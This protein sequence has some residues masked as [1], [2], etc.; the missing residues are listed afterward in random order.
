MKKNKKLIPKNTYYCYDHLK[1]T[2]KSRYKT[3]G[4]CPYWSI[5]KKYPKQNN[6]YCAYLE[7]GD[8]DINAEKRWTNIYYV[9]K[10]K[11]KHKKTKK[12]YV[13]AYEIGFPMSLIWDQVKECGINEE[14]KCEDKKKNLR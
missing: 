9:D 7:K 14:N 13:S 3:I 11:K 10:K 5:N 1:V 4:I 6:G 12:R 2:K 8:W